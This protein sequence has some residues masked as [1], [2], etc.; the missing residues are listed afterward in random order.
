MSI[1]RQLASRY[2]KQC[3]TNENHSDPELTTR[4]Y[5]TNTA[6]M[7]QT[8]EDLFKADQNVN[9]LS[10]SRERGEIAAEIKKNKACFAI[11]TV[12]TVRPF[13]TAV[14]INISTEQSSPA[15]VH[16]I[17]KGEVLSIYEKVNKRHDFL[18]SARNADK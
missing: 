1:F 18:G 10:I 14:D 17:L 3:E 11:V 2:K 16:P 13:E 9:I 15:G 4:Y 5:R 7:M 6:Q 8:I 12:V